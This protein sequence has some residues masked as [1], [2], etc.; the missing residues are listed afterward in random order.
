MPAFRHVIGIFG[1]G[2]IPADTFT[3][4]EDGQTKN[5]PSPGVAWDFRPVP[6]AETLSLLV[7]SEGKLIR[8][9]N[10]FMANLPAGTLVTFSGLTIDTKSPARLDIG[11]VN[12]G[13]R[14]F[15]AAPL[16]AFQPPAGDPMLASPT[17]NT[18]RLWASRDSDDVTEVIGDDGNIN[19]VQNTAWVVQGRVPATGL[20][21]DGGQVWDVTAVERIGDSDLFRVVGQRNR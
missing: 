15:P 12:V 17:G 13:L 5:L 18:V 10:G 3:F 19:V 16:P 9:L 1:P 2:D 21:E 7:T 8:P 14:M 4:V 20:V 11:Q 6:G